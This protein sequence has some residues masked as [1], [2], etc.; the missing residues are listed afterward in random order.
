MTPTPPAIVAQARAELRRAVTMPSPLGID[1]KFAL[2]RKADA[3]LT[4]L[5]R[6]P[7]G[8]LVPIAMILVAVAVSRP[9]RFRLA[10]LSELYRWA[11]VL[12]AGLVAMVATAVLAALV[13]D[14][15]VQ[16]PAVCLAAAVPWVLAACAR[17]GLTSER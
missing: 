7:E 8:V 16:V 12:Q 10:W 17:E 15:G 2:V 4:S 1:S 5:T 14:S 9:D 3:M 13:N 6:G 11:P